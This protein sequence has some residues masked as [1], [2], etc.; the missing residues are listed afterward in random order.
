M[1]YYGSRGM[2]QTAYKVTTYN[3]VTKMEGIEI[4]NNERYVQ[5]RGLPF[6][7][8]EKVEVVEHE[9]D[10]IHGLGGVTPAFQRMWDSLK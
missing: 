7:H 1:V 3:N 4:C 8:I 5:L 10:Y 2:K 6:I 9:E